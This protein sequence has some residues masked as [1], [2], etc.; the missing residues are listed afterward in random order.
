MLYSASVKELNMPEKKT[1]T[2]IV[3]YF[4]NLRRKKNTKLDAI[5]SMIEW[6]PIAKKLDKRFIR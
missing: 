2:P 6:K 1:A 4:V 3:D 5:D